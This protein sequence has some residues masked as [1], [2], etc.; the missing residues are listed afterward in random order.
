MNPRRR[1]TDPRY[2]CAMVVI[3]LGLGVGIAVVIFAFR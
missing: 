1:Y 2:G 3:E